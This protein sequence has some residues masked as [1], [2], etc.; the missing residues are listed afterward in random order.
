MVLSLT[1]V[2]KRKIDFTKWRHLPQR[3]MN[4]QMNGPQSQLCLLLHKSINPKN[5]SITCGVGLPQH[6][7]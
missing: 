2:E 1:F 5:N 4:F 7:K 3:F 6:K